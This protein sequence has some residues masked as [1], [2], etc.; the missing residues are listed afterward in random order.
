MNYF[1]VA[2]VSAGTAVVS[3]G[4]SVAGGGDV[5]STTVVSAAVPSV[6]VS[7]LLHENKVAVNN[8][9]TNSKLR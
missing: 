8:S 6:V 7:L 1:G 2:V 9:A 4:M 3:A 5:V